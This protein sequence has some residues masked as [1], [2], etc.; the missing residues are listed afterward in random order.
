MKNNFIIIFLI[1]LALIVVAKS[2]GSTV[3]I[4]SRYSNRLAGR[5][6]ANGEIYD[7]KKLTAAHLKLPFGTRVKVTN[8][9]NNETVVVRIND[10]GPY[11]K[12]RIIDLSYA[13][14]R[15]IGMLKKGIVKVRIER[16]KG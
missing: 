6:T 10:R 9:E 4:A 12:G 13:A 3:G 7:P 1:A 15:Q 11:V 8:L 16:V 14:A 2:C 5:K